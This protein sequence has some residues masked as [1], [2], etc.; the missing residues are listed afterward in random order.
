M[1]MSTQ[2][3]PLVPETDERAR[4]RTAIGLEATRPTAKA[5]PQRPPRTGEPTGCLWAMVLPVVAMIAVTLLLVAARMIDAPITWPQVQGWASGWLGGVSPVADAA[6]HL[7]V[8]DDFTQ[9]ASI[10][11]ATEQSG[12][13]SA[14]LRPDEGAYHMTIH[15]ERL[16]W[17]TIGASALKPFFAEAAFTVSALTP[18]G[19]T[20]LLARRQDADNAY[21]F[22]I[23]GTG[24]FQIQLLQEGKMQTLTPWLADIAIKPAGVAN[25]LAVEDDGKVLRFFVNDILFYETDMAE[26]SA[27]DVGLFGAA[28]VNEHAEIDVDWLRVYALPAS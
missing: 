15:P 17:S 13:W 9:T 25:Q 20:G 10:L 22:A 8:A 24:E 4:K 1:A 14:Q 16:V 21:L 6:D 5:V 23:N 19:I 7:V 26:L 27:G 12:E 3:E 2:N 28:P 11:A 18:A